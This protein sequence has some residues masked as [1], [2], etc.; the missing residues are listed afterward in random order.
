[1][2]ALVKRGDPVTLIARIGKV[3]A[4]VL[5]QAKADGIKGELVTV[6]NLTSKRQVRAKV[7]G[8]DLVQAVMP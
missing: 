1:M 8:Q 4:R 2:P 7:V 5:A 3:E 6:M